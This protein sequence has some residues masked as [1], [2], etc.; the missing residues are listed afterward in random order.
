MNRYLFSLLLAFAGGA[1]VGQESDS[2][3]HYTRVALR[4]NPGVKAAYHDY[5]AA[6]KAAKS[7]GAFDDPTLEIGIFPRPLEYAGE[8]EIARFQLMQMFPWF[9]TRA[10]ARDESEHMAR[11][12]REQYRERVDALRAEVAA[13]WY[14]LCLAR[15]RW[16]ANEEQLQ[17][18]EQLERLAAR[19]FAAG[20]TTTATY[21]NE[22]RDA[23]SMTAATPAAASGMTGMT[24]NMPAGKSDAGSM[25]AMNDNGM[26]G[27]GAGLANVLRLQA[28]RAGLES[29]AGAILSELA[30]G[31]ATFNALLDREPWHE[32]VIP[33]SCP[34]LAVAFDAGEIARL[35]VERNPALAMIREERL[36]AGARTDM[37]RKM[38]Y[39]MFGVG[40]QYML[41]RPRDGEMEMNGNAG[42]IMPMFSIT[43]P[44]SRGKYRAAREQGEQLQRASD[45][46]YRDAYR[47][48]EAELY[49]H[50]RALDEATR[51]IALARK[52]TELARAARELSLRALASGNGALDDALQVQRQLSGYRLDEAAAIIEYNAAAAAALQLIPPPREQ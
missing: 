39:P 37:A 46:R 28:E 47:R 6:S 26:S 8:R 3:Q 22:K 45:E 44:V 19:R 9:G 17:L 15:R 36:A 25:S 16:L 32:V 12:A 21:T 41:T 24:T 14:D 30:A 51:K 7:A 38:G 48:L 23:K 2:L 10:A 1:V 33:D 13:R 5:M 34:L 43:I 18:L 52:R 20:T 29:E 42:M 40:A 4:D 50:R 11:M 27:S 35:L 31:K 49:R